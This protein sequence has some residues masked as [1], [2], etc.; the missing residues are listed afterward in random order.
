MF[1]GTI[2][3]RYAHEAIQILPGENHCSVECRSKRFCHRTNFARRGTKSTAAT[4][5]HWIF[6]WEQD[7]G[8]EDDFRRGRLSKITSKISDY[9]EQQLEDDDETT[10]VELQRLIAR[11]FGVD[12]RS[13]SIQRHLRESLQ[14]AVVG[15]RCGPMISDT[16][17]Q[18]RVEFA[19]MCLENKDNFDNM[20]WTDESS[21][22]LKRHCQ[23]MRVKMGKEVPFKPVAKHALK[24]HVWAGISKR[25]ATKICI[26]DQTMDAPGFLVLFIE[27][28]FGGM[29]YRFMQD[30]DPK[31][32]YQPIGK[33]IL[34]GGRHKLA[35][36]T[37]Q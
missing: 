4:F 29:N 30:N 22:Q 19:R 16:N 1:A 27:K 26:F 15:T 5:R 24:V 17:K 11:K 20:I 31:H 2:A 21:V 8:L 23:N 3:S 36:H 12:I 9:M 34:C 28:H 35:A 13:A 14:W 32:T 18:K 10:S 7:R 25:G 33:G 37:F 6:H